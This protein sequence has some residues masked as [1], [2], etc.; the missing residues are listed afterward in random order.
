LISWLVSQ[1]EEEFFEEGI[2]LIGVVYKESVAR[3]LENL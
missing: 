3:A 1:I 2:E